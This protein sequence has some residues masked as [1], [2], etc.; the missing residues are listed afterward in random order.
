MQSLRWEKER[1]AVDARLNSLYQHNISCKVW[2]DKKTTWK[3]ERMPPGKTSGAIRMENK[4]AK[5]S[6]RTENNRRTTRQKLWE[7]RWPVR[8]DIVEA[9]VKA[10]EREWEWINR[11]WQMRRQCGWRHAHTQKKKYMQMHSTK[12]MTG[13]RN[14]TFLHGNLNRFW[15]KSWKRSPSM[16]RCFTI[17]QLQQQAAATLQREAPSL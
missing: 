17:L 8:S 15:D 14:T 3:K 7:G 13:Q 2:A 11:A 4:H 9:K 10:W 5:G 1:L 6:Q 12:F 16:S